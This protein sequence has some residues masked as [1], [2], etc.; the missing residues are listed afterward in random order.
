MRSAERVVRLLLAEDHAPLARTLAEGLTQAG[1][2]ALQRA[3]LPIYAPVEEAWAPL[4][5]AAAAG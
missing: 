2:V 4:A 5:A 1:Q 3:P